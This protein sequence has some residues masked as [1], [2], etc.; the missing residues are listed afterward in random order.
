MHCMR[1][2]EGSP[3]AIKYI[4]GLAPRMTHAGVDFWSPEVSIGSA[5]ANTHFR[6]SSSILLKCRMM[7]TVRGALFDF[8]PSIFVGRMPERVR[9]ILSFMLI[10]S[11]L[12]GILFL[13]I[14][15]KPKK[16]GIITIQKGLCFLFKS[17]EITNLNGE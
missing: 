17:S 9:L 14:F 2:R 5:M 15:L 11:P 16:P 8:I 7:H 6:L 10:N 12:K 13:V 4:G 3:F 1:E